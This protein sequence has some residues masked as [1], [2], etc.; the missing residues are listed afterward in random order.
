MKIAL[1]SEHASPL[2]TRALTPGM[3]H[4]QWIA[5]E[6]G[7]EGCVIFVCRHRRADQIDYCCAADVFV[8]TP[9]HDPFGITPLEAMAGAVRF[10]VVFT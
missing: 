3:G 6:E 5:R 1:I 4:L 7:I 9:W 2:A 8:S 10:R